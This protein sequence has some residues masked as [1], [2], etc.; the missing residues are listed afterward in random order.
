MKFCSVSLS[1]ILF[2]PWKAVFYVFV[3]QQQQKKKEPII[4]QAVCISGGEP[5][6]G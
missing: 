6:S 4:L 2:S 5:A 1:N 3:Q